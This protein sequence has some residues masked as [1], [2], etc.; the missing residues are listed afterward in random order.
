MMADRIV[1]TDCPHCGKYT[2]CFVMIGQ[3]F[4][5]VCAHC[6]KSA[7]LDMSGDSYKVMLRKQ[8]NELEKIGDEYYNR[9]IER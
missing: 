8:L 4:E 9:L 2:E 1:A 7:E 3:T 5:D 6:N